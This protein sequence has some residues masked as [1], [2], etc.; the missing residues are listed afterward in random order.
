MILELFRGSWTFWRQFQSHL[1]GVE[2]NLESAEGRL[3]Q[4]EEDQE[5]I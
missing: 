4:A 1:G 2:T 3:R 5:E